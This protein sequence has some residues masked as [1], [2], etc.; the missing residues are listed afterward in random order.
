MRTTNK[1]QTLLEQSIN[2]GIV[3]KSEREKLGMSKYRASELTGLSGTTIENIEQGK[4]PTIVSVRS[5][6]AVLGYKAPLIKNDE[7]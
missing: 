3:L 6:A 5:Y 1:N 7:V 4:C 2:D